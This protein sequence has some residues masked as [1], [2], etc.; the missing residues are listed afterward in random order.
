MIEILLAAILV[1]L[2][3]IRPKRDYYVVEWRM[4]NAA[5][6][7]G[8]AFD[9]EPEA[10]GKDRLKAH[11]L[12][13]DKAGRTNGVLLNHRDG[14]QIFLSQDVFEELDAAQMLFDWVVSRFPRHSSFYSVAYLRRIRA[15]SPKQGMMLPPDVGAG[16][17]PRTLRRWPEER[18][19]EPPTEDEVA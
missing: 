18:W 5:P 15:S 11:G 12:S 8:I 9:D 3:V 10:L 17:N 19:Y 6:L 7:N 13:V 1:S 16:K 2:W 4:C 14:G